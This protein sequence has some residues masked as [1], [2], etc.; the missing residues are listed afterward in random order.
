MR[1]DCRETGSSKQGQE[2]STWVLPAPEILPE[3]EKLVQVRIRDSLLRLV[4][5]AAHS[6]GM[7]VFHQLPIFPVVDVQYQCGAF[8]SG[9]P[10]RSQVEKRMQLQPVFYIDPVVC[11]ESSHL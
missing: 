2:R 6:V 8:Q 1:W 5:G 11:S 9:R 3:K 4:S 7:G 10:G